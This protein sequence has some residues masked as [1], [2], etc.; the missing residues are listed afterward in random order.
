MGMMH[1]KRTQIVHPTLFL[2]HMHVSTKELKG[3]ESQ[4]VHIVKPQAINHYIALADTIH[5]TGSLL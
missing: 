4:Y 2:G 3:L 5:R 1:K